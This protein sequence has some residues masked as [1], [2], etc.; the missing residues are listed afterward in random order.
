MEI[1]SDLALTPVAPLGVSASTPAGASNSAAAS[2]HAPELTFSPAQ[3]GMLA[4]LVSEVAFFGTLITAYVAY[5]GQDTVG[6]TPREALSLPLT[7][8]TTAC[9]LASS[10]TI[11][12]AMSRLEQGRSR[13]FVSAWATTIVL[14]IAFLLGTAYEWRQLIVEHHL[15]ISR[16][17][18]GTTFYTLV[19]FHGLHV[20]I[21]I[22]VML[23][24]LGL[25]M[26]G[27]LSA[28]GLSEN[29]SR[30]EGQAHFA[31]T[32]S[33]NE[34]NPDGS[35]IAAKNPAGVQLVS[36][37]WHFVDVVWIV[38]FTLVYLIGR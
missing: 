10:W 30:R 38:V 20:T 11:H 5:L 4:F 2:E 24:V 26:A 33:Q 3:L 31:Y 7:L 37:Y 16:N 22:F 8:G 32:A 1:N 23:V 34:P 35:R 15:T 29:G 18:F 25:A 13:E 9:L 19:G 14:G 27:Q 17:L 28:E 6:P 12:L 36:W 21:G